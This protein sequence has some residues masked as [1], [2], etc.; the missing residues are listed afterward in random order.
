MEPWIF[1]RRGKHA[2]YCTTAGFG[3]YLS[4]GLSGFTMYSI[5]EYGTFDVGRIDSESCLGILECK[6]GITE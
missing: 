1:V 2:S 6:S 4:S 3:V 5:L